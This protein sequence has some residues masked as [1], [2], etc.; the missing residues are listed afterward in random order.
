MAEVDGAG[1]PLGYL[2]TDTKEATVEDKA[3]CR[4]PSR[5]LRPASVSKF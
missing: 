1:V 3:R 4:L 2:L 5:R